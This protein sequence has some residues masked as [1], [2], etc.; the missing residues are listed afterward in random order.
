MNKGQ[1][2]VLQRIVQV[3]VISKKGKSYEVT[4]RF[5]REFRDNANNTY[6]TIDNKNNIN[7]VFLYRRSEELR[8]LIEDIR[9]ITHVVDVKYRI[10]IR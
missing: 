9:S 4:R 7:A 1:N 5:L 10:C 8:N 6:T 3:K 2:A